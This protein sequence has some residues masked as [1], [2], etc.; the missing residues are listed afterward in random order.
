M[1]SYSAVSDVTPTGVAEAVAR[2]LEWFES[3]SGWAPPDPETLAELAA[4]GVC[5]APDDCL[6]T[7]GGWCEHG[8]ASWALIL[9][10]LP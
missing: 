3:N 8:L 4:D 9:A 6:T 7:P 2:A 10:E 1:S 5:R